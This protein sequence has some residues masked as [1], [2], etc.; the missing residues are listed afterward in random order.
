MVVGRVGAGWWVWV[1]CG[2]AGG[3][4]GGWE[5]TRVELGL[6]VAGE[7]L[8]CALGGWGC[9][10]VR[11]GAGAGAGGGEQGEENCGGDE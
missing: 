1:S 10:L 4:K 3:G 2:R 6:Y 7:F 9:A 5:V 8:S 11:A